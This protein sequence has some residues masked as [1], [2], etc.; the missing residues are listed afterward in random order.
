VLISNAKTNFEIVKNLKREDI[1]NYLKSITR[2]DIERF[3]AKSGHKVWFSLAFLLFL[4]GFKKLIKPAKIINK[5]TNPLLLEP[6][7]QN[8]PVY[9]KKEI[10]RA[11]QRAREFNSQFE[12]EITQTDRYGNV[13]GRIRIT[14]HDAVDRVL[15]EEVTKYARTYLTEDQ[16]ALSNILE[17][18][19]LTYGEIFKSYW[20][21]KIPNFGL[22]KDPSS[23]AKYIIFGGFMFLI[24]GYRHKDIY[25]KF[26]SS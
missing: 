16:R 12:Q 13:T 8:M 21:I 5:E 19:P 14:D 4:Y 18:G 22:P 9:D 20:G 11:L 15:N 7:D 6:M 24:L 3:I 2:K 17:Q 1:L 23:I 26:K 25:K 10:K